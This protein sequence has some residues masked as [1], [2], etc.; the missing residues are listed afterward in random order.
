MTVDELIAREEIRRTLAQYNISGDANDSDGY[1]GAFAEDGVLESA[2][3]TITGRAQIRDWKEARTKN[4]PAR[5][6]RHNLTTCQIEITGAETATARTYFVVFTE[7][8]ADHNGYYS[9][10]FRK[11]GDRWLI[12]HRKIWL[13]WRAP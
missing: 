10:Q 1:A 13:D 5:F 9:D 11:A 3:F 6:V 2:D 4:P 12:A 7:I 8:G